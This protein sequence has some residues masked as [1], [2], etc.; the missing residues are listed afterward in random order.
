M[1]APSVVGCHGACAGGI[2]PGQAIEAAA[3][4]DFP[5]FDRIVGG[6]LGAV[7]PFL[8]FFSGLNVDR[9][10]LLLSGLGDLEGL[11]ADECGGLRVVAHESGSGGA[12][13]GIPSDCDRAVVS[14]SRVAC[15]DR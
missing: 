4:A 15:D 5:G 3:A 2:C 7:F 14:D 13:R 6:S 8:S 12:G 9:N 11:G 10:T 1:L